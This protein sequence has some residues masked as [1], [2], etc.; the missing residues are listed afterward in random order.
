MKTTPEADCTMG[1]HL[2]I[3]GDVQRVTA[4]ITTFDWRGLICSMCLDPSGVEESEL[5]SS[6]EVGNTENIG[7]GF[8]RDDGTLLTW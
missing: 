6:A 2:E 3:F 8:F 5:I 7:A 1:E 4:E